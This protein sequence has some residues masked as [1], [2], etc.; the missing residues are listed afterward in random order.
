[1]PY[2]DVTIAQRGKVARLVAAVQEHK[3]ATGEHRS[4]MKCACGATLHF[5]IQ[6]TGSSRAHCAAG[7][8]IRWAH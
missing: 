2:Q 3:P 6:A 7:C 1:M 5:H 4:T 8:G